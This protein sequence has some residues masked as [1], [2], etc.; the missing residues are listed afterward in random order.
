MLT[1]ADLAN[2]KTHAANHNENNMAYLL[3]AFSVQRLHLCEFLKSVKSKAEQWNSKHP[4]LLTPM[5][6][7]DL[8]YFVAE[9]DD[10]HLAKISEIHQMLIEKTANE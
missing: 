4:R 2:R 3:K 1:E 10:H 5:R 9:H 6:P 7:I 8:A